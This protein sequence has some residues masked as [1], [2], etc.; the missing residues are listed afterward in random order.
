[1]VRRKSHDPMPGG[2]T[3][4]GH[5]GHERRRGAAEPRGGAGASRP[6][7]GQGRLRAA[8]SRQPRAGLCA[9]LPDG[10]R[11]R[12]GRGAGP[13]RLRAGLAEAGLVPGRER[14]LVLAAPADGER[15]AVRAAVAAEAGVEGHDD[16]RPDH[17]RA[18]GTAGS[19]GRPGSGLRPGA[20]AGHPAPRGASGVRAPRR[21]GLQAR[22]DRGADRGGDGHVQGP[23]PPRPEAAAGVV[24]AMTCPAALERMDDHV[25]GILDEAA[26]QEMELHVASCAECRAEERSLRALLAHAAALPDARPPGRDLWPGIA[27]RIGGPRVG[28][29]AWPRAGWTAGLAAAAAVV[30]ALSALILTYRAGARSGP[31]TSPGSLVPAAVRGGDEAV[32]AA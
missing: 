25:D 11:A 31:S 4:R 16:R 8:L 19:L 10:R 12:P 5:P 21:G 23:A 9:L 27:S 32:A 17:V 26:D 2:R 13:R 6:G 15:G 18:A 7:R 14:V 29:R 20:R 22:G 3:R 30:L 28:G 24:D 1:M